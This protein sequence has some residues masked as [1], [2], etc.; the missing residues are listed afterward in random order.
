[1]LDAF[2]RLGRTFPGAGFLVS[3]CG[4][5]PGID[6]LARRASGVRLRVTLHPAFQPVR[7]VLVPGAARWGVEGLAGALCRFG[8]AAVRAQGREA[9]PVEVAWGLLPGVNDT[10]ADAHR[11]ASLLAG[12]PCTVQV[13]RLDVDLGQA[14]VGR[15]R[16]VASG[17][18][19]CLSGASGAVGGGGLDADDFARELAVSGLEARAAPGPV[20]PPFGQVLSAVGGGRTS[21]REGFTE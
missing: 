12:C 8:E 4:V 21:G 2:G 3:T 17:V 7:D 1:M 19:D 9:A 15:A 16:A 13:A 11:V 5:V 14:W 6:E 18:H 10:V 20:P